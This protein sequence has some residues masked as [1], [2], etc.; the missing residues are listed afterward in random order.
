MAK[1]EPRQPGQ[2]GNRQ[3]NPD[4]MNAFRARQAF[5]R[6]LNSLYLE[7]KPALV[8]STSRGSEGTIFVQGGG[9]YTKDAPEAPAN[10]VLSPL[11]S[12]PRR[13]SNSSSARGNGCIGPFPRQTS[14]GG[15]IS[16]MC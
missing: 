14:T 1:A 9:Q 3:G 15:R 4:A 12:T 11:L 10:V 16:R 8:L 5:N 6:V 13:A 2:G 7:E